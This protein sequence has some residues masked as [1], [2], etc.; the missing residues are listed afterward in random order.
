M[1]SF[2][3]TAADLA[4][5]LPSAGGADMETVETSNRR[6]AML[7]AYH[8]LVRA[9]TMRDAVQRAIGLDQYC[10][11]DGLIAIELRKALDA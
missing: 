4:M 11:R 1:K 9:G 3:D 10:G 6:A 7:A 8:A 2:R 5:Q